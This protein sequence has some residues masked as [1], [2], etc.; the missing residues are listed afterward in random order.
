MASLFGHSLWIHPERKN[1]QGVKKKE[2]LL[3]LRIF[4][5]IYSKSIKKKRGMLLLD[6]VQLQGN[7]CGADQVALATRPPPAR[8]CVNII[9][10]NKALYQILS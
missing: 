1:T 7:I 2:L 9:Q 8:N 6:V 4:T 3:N 10:C 5:D